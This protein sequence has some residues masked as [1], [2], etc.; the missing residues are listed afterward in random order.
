[1]SSV[2]AKGQRGMTLLEVMVAIAV[3]MLV[4]YS[5]L[6]FQNYSIDQLLSM[7]QQQRALRVAQNQMVQARLID[8]RSL[9]NDAGTESQGGVVLHWQREVEAVDGFAMKRMIV[10]VRAEDSPRQLAELTGYRASPD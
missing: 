4:G 2:G 3:L 9:R 8:Y 6:Q 1:M 7:Q 5:A 10:Q